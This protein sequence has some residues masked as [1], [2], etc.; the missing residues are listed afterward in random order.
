MA[1]LTK[2]RSKKAGLPPG[3]LIH[4]GEK[5]T[6]KVKI[7]IIE[8]DEMHFREQEAKTIEECFPLKDKDRPTV[9]WINIDGIHQS[10]ILG[11]L[12]EG[13]G[14]HPL[15]VEDILNTDQRPKIEE[16]EGYNYIVLKTLQF[17]G[18]DGEIIAEQVS[19]ILGPNF[20]ISFQEKEVDI[21]HAIMES[22]RTNK[23]RIRKMGADYLAYCL[24]DAIVDN[25]FTIMETLET[26]REMATEMLEIYLSSI[27]NRLNTVIKVLTLI[28]TIFMPLTLITGIYGMNFK[29][30]PELGWR[31]G[32]PMILFIMAGAGIA[33]VYYFKKKK[34]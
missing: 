7:T 16:F 15:I 25:Y 5:K 17:H 21:F 27:S 34:W 19:L 32:Y 10:E 9:A 6:E 30:M 24:L 1:K 4:I 12:G 22:L 8:Y 26:F 23:G 2:K 33:M 20:V 29:Y 18:N 31:W 28:A 13:F 14:L 11:K 3:T